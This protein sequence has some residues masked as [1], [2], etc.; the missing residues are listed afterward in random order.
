MPVNCFLITV[1]L[2]HELN[3]ICRKRPAEMFNIFFLVATEAIREL[4]AD[5]EYLGE[6]IGLIATLRTWSRSK[7]QHMHIHYLVPGGGIS[8]NGKYWLFPNFTQLVIKTYQ[9]VLF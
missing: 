3:A 8:P 9:F 2:P 6:K 4:A 5:P 7:D 1:T